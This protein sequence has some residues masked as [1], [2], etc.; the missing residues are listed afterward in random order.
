[1]RPSLRS[2]QWF[3][4]LLVFASLMAC[5]ANGFHLRDD[6]PLPERYQTIYVEGLESDA[7]RRQLKDKVE[8]QG[9]SLVDSKDQ[10][11]TILHFSEFKQGK[12]VSG[13]GENREVRQ[14][15]IFLKMNYR[16][17]DAKTRKEL[18][19]KARISIDKTQIYDSAFV[20]GKVEE[21]RLINEELRKDAARQ[22]LIK[23]RYGSVK[24]LL[25]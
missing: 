8:E 20:L 21:E 4:L 14:Y 24:A 18:F 16:V 3:F 9:A 5:G 23:L 13:Y 12:S 2:A 19:P 11:L 17:L 15:L 25:K 22:I 1:M 7:F 10:A 6:M